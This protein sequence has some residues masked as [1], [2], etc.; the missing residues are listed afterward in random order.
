MR[1]RHALLAS[2]LLLAAAP[3][4]AQGGVQ[5]LQTISTSG[6]SIRVNNCDL[7]QPQINPN[8]AATARCGAAAMVASFD[9]KIN[10]TAPSGLTITTSGCG[11]LG[12]CDTLDTYTTI[13]NSLRKPTVAAAYNYFTVTASWTGGN[14]TTSVS[15]G[16]TLLPVAVSNSVVS[17]TGGNNNG[18]ALGANS[19]PVVLA[20]DETVPVSSTT[21]A[22]EAGGNLAT[23]AAAVG[24]IPAKGSATSANST[25]VAIASDQAPVP[26]QPSGLSSAIVA[27]QQNV[28]ASAV[29]L[30]SNSVHGFCVK[31]LPGNTITAYVGPSGVTTSTGY[32]LA[33][34]DWICYQGSNTNL[35]YVI[36]GS[37]S[38]AQVA[39]SGN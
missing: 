8:A 26:T 22:K 10:G 31:A 39:V 9:L 13:A 5:S 18:Q 34:G 19:A 24:N 11:L 30:A 21:L 35:A 4:F 36:A 12:G 28:T 32:P 7:L 3:L 16:A 37:G 27:F 2:V 14:S 1:L 33:P 29:A 23:I 20:S 25:P 15:V 17:I 6:K 38:G